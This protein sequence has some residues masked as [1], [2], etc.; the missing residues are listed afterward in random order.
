MDISKYPPPIQRICQRIKKDL[1]KPPIINGRALVLQQLLNDLSAL[2]TSSD[3]QVLDTIDETD[4]VETFD[5]ESPPRSRRP[6]E[7]EEDDATYIQRVKTEM[8]KSGRDT[9]SRYRSSKDSIMK[10]RTTPKEHAPVRKQVSFQQE[11][12]DVESPSTTSRSLSLS[13][14]KKMM[15]LSKRKKLFRQKPKEEEK[16]D[17][18][19]NETVHDHNQESESNDDGHDDDDGEMSD[20][21]QGKLVLSE[22]PTPRQQVKKL[23]PK[24]DSIRV[25]KI[26]SEGASKRKM[27]FTGTTVEEEDEGEFEEEKKNEE[28]ERDGKRELNEKSESSN[29]DEEFT[30]RKTLSLSRSA[31][32][33]RHE[34][35]SLKISGLS[36]DDDRKRG[37]DEINRSRPTS[38]KSL[39]SNEDTEGVIR[40]TTLHEEASESSHTVST[41]QDLH[42]NKTKI[43]ETKSLPIAVSQHKK[44][45][46]SRS[47]LSTQRKMF[48]FDHLPDQSAPS[49]SE[50]SKESSR[51]PGGE[52]TAAEIDNHPLSSTESVPEPPPLTPRSPRSP[53]PPN[54]PTFEESRIVELK[55]R[56]SEDTDVS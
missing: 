15:K 23:E 53:K 12:E 56:I 24:S 52:P 46:S 48:L 20:D 10:R 1:V 17:I 14:P 25:H 54:I 43:E 49:V 6:V 39:T 26:L 27:F 30:H 19:Q 35:S 28:T 33:R 41:D 8:R 40:N 13:S 51:Q 36:F 9:R 45:E 22:S 4:D 31:G 2:A 34:P 50:D 29:E 55:R 3:H 42:E 44:L 11:N 21:S 7:E 18:I 16:E 32:M 38:T 5:L 37:G 47:A